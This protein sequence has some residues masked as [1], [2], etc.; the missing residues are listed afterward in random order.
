MIIHQVEGLVIVYW[1][2]DVQTIRLKWETLYREDSTL[3]DAL[4]WC[5]TYVQQHKRVIAK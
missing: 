2:K 4:E 3:R 1:E 5:F